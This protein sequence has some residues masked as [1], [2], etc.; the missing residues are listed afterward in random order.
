MCEAK[1]KVWGRHSQF[2]IELSRFARSEEKGLVK[3]FKAC[4]VKE[5]SSSSRFAKRETPLRQPSAGREE[6]DPGDRFPWETL[7]GG[8]PVRSTKRRDSNPICRG[9]AK[10]ESALAADFRRGVPGAKHQ[11]AGFAPYLPGLHRGQRTG[12]SSRVPGGGFRQRKNES[13]DK[14]CGL[15]IAIAAMI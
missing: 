10:R 4:V 2:L 7:A 15:T 11:K 8:F 14:T 1:R 3:L 12:F 6:N 5:Q 9:S 13:F